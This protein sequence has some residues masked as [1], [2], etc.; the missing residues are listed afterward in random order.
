M[1]RGRRDSIAGRGDDRFAVRA[2]SA[3]PAQRSD[4]ALAGA[5]ADSPLVRERLEH[6]AGHGSG[7]GL[8]MALGWKQHVDVG[9]WRRPSRK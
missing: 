2:V 4:V 3:S 5:A 7:L 8:Q 1:T 9:L 6:E